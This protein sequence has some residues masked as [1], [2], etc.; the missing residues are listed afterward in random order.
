MKA[1]EM[2]Q[3]SIT[4]DA[5]GKILGRLATEVA[6][7]LRGKN[8]VDFAYNKVDGAKVTI[9][10]ASQVKVTGNKLDDKMYYTHSGYLGNLKSKTLKVAMKNPDFVIR[11]AVKGMLPKNK[12]TQKFLNNLTVVEGEN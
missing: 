2:T 8:H 12:L 1:R 3:D 5:K 7:L 10:N 11:H 6:E 4:I 9:I